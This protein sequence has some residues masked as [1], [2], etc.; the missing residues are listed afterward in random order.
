MRLLRAAELDQTCLF[1]SHRCILPWLLCWLWFALL[2]LLFRRPGAAYHYVL[3]TTASRIQRCISRKRFPWIW[4]L[5]AQH[6]DASAPLELEASVLKSKSSSPSLLCFFVLRFFLLHVIRRA[7]LFLN[8]TTTTVIVVHAH[9]IRPQRCVTGG[10]LCLVVH[11]VSNGEQ[12]TWTPVWS[13]SPCPH[14]NALCDPTTWRK[15]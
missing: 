8:D 5:C 10:C 14:R 3:A 12:Q 4:H 6:G 9:Q 13:M 2:F 11:I 7:F 15:Q 1:V